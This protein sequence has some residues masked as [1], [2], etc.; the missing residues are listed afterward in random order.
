MT[1]PTR[2]ADSSGKSLAI[3][4]NHQIIEHIEMAA[5]L[6]EG[7]FRDPTPDQKEENQCT[8]AH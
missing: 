8:D 5:R 6:Q 2:P 4:N 1:Q 7:D 3:L